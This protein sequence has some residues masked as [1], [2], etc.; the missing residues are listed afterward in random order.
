MVIDEV[1]VHMNRRRS[2]D[3]RDGRSVMPGQVVRE[4][5]QIPMQ[6]VLRPCHHCPSMTTRQLTMQVS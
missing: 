4:E 2:D 5:L 6:Q 3:G 1:K